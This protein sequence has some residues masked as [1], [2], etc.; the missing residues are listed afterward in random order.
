[1]SKSLIAPP[2]KGEGGRKGIGRGK[3]WAK[4]I[5][6][7]STLLHMQI[8]KKVMGKIKKNEGLSMVLKFFGHG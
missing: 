7:K 8:L 4:T 6:V 2:L 3:I 1:M 5:K